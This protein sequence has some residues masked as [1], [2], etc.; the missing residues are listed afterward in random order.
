VV[1]AGKGAEHGGRLRI[2]GQ[3]DAVRSELSLQ[4]SVHL[5]GRDE[6]RGPRRFDQ[7]VG[8]EHGV[9]VDVAAA[10]VGDPGDVVDGGDEVMRRAVARHGLAHLGELGRARKRGVRRAVLVHRRG[11]QGRTVGPNLGEEVEVRAQVQAGLLERAAQLVGGGEPEHLAIDRD[12]VA[13]LQVLDHPF[14]VVRGRAGGDAHELHAGARDLR[15]GLHPI[16]AVGE[17]RGM[18]RGDHER[19]HRAG[20]PGQPDAPLPA[21]GKV[22]RQVRIAGRH[23][24]GGKLMLRERVAGLLD[25]QSERRGAGVH[26]VLPKGERG[27]LGCGAP[28][29][30]GVPRF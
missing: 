19:A 14:D 16:A 9:V 18:I 4:G 11:R 1:P 2:V 24:Q 12:G 26:G 17:E 13:G 21:V 10:Q 30:R 8:E 7:Q 3:R 29:T 6:Q 25:A 22:L 23:E 28:Q 15:L 5:A 20:E 27:G